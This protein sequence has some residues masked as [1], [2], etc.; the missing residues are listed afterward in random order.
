MLASITSFRVV[1][2]ASPDPALS[3]SVVTS[4][5]GSISSPGVVTSDP[6]GSVI[7]VTS[8][9]VG[10]GGNLSGVTFRHHDEESRLAKGGRVAVIH[11]KRQ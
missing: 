10:G 9:G 4:L 5:G 11:L 6:E 2:S 8:P 1:S 3:L 7:I